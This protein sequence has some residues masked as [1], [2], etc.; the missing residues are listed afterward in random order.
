MSEAYHQRMAKIK[1]R[2]PRAYEQWSEDDEA[3]LAEMFL[4]DLSMAEMSAALQR[5]PGAIRSRMRKRH[6]DSRPPVP[7]PV[8]NMP[9]P[10]PPL[11]EH[12]Q[13]TGESFRLQFVFQWHTVFRNVTQPYCFPQSITPYMRHR[14]HRAVVYRWLVCEEDS[15]KPA[16]MYIGTTKRLCPDR[17]EGYLQPTGNTNQRLAGLFHEYGR[18]GYMIYLEILGKCHVQADADIQMPYHIRSQARRLVLEELLIDYHKQQG[19]DL[20]NQ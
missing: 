6:L 14:Y 13:I 8:S 19:Y 11:E 9:Q 5:Q 7:S 15:D 20:L 2:Y 16:L 3:L 12:Q 1:A 18:E 10:E 17:L 4:A